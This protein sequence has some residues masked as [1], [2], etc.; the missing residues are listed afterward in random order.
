MSRKSFPEFYGC[1]TCFA[2]LRAVGEVT[3]AH[4]ALDA[5][6]AL[7]E[8]TGRTYVLALEANEERIRR[9]IKQA[10]M[11]QRG[12]DLHDCEHKEEQEE[13]AQKLKG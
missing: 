6:V 1:L 8:R 13:W 11:E 5:V 10:E 9:A 3:A 7:G 12:F 4:E 2:H